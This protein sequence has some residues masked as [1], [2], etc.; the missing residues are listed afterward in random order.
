MKSTHLP[1]VS[2]DIVAV[3]G[4][5]IVDTELRDLQSAMACLAE[6][7]TATEAIVNVVP[8]AQGAGETAKIQIE[9]FAADGSTAG[10]SAVNVYW[11]ALGK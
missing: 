1:E 5:L 11:M 10:A 2:G 4:T 7:S 6:S 9:V 8:Q 3:T